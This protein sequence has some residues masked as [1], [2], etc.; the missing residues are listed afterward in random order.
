MEPQQRAI[1]QAFE[2][3]FGA[4]PSFLVRAPG[5]VNLIGEHTDYNEGYVLPMAI[6]RAVRIALRPRPDRRAVVH[7]LEYNETAEFALDDL[8]KDKGWAEYVKG[9]AWAMQQ[10]G[11]TLSGWDGV[12]TGDIP[13][14]AG[15]SSSSAVTV[16][17]ILAFA[18]ASDREPDPV[19]AALLG[20]QAEDGW[21]GVHGGIMDQ[22][23]CLLARAG[24]AL[25]LD[26]RTLAYEHIPLPAGMAV[27]VL[28]TSTRRGLVNSAY[29]ERRRQCDAAAKALEVRA[30]RD[31]DEAG[32]R[33]RA[34]RLDETTRRRARHVITENGRVLQAVEAMRGGD[35]AALGLL[36]DAS[37]AS[38]RDDFEV[39]SKALNAI[40]ELARRQPG[41]FG[42]RLTGAGFAGCA[43]ALVEQERGAE[44]AAAVAKEYEQATGMKPAISLTDA[45]AGAGIARLTG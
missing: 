12:M 19:R 42:A 41:C 33:S 28:D 8:Q 4:K 15:L 7:S 1:V 43:V 6:D 24:H 20:H 31:V 2:T 16:A 11:W 18:A 17:S 38:L 13:L 29:N 26:C 32:F 14:G 35:A 37:H 3:H 30:L 40:V 45:A 22:M 10:A 21:V 36:L 39:S 25:F 34:D 23:V 9:A 44:F 5:R 27:A